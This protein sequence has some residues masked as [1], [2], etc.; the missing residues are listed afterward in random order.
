M[1]LTRRAANRGEGEPA[2]NET[3]ETKQPQQF[4][5]NPQ[6]NA[7]I[8]EY[9]KENGKHFA[10]IQAMPRD[11]LERA[12]VLQ[13]VQKNDRVA[14]MR[15]GIQRKLDQDPELKAAY[16]NLVKNLPEDQREQAMVNIAARTMRDIV[17][18]EAQKAG[19]KV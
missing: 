6:V 2:A 16:A 19:V 5:D 7:K 18:R 13:E 8:D 3:A 4:R 10:Y 9:I 11:R 14:K 12:L 15:A 1:S 17:P